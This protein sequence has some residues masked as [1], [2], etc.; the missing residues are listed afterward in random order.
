MLDGSF[1][2]SEALAKGLVTRHQLYGPRFRRVLPDV[3]VPAGLK[4]DLPARSQAAY[5]LVRNRGGVLAGYSAAA[6][7]GAD[8]APRRAPAEVLV[9]TR[10]R[11]QPGLRVHR[12]RVEPGE[13]V[14]AG[15]CRMTGALRTAWDLARWR[16]LVDGVVA[17]D[18]L[19][20]TGGFSPAALL[21]P[22][23]GYPAARGCRRLPAVVE[24]ADPRAESPMETRVRVRLILAGLP[25]PEVQFRVV[26]EYG[27]VLARVDL[28]Y[29]E[30]KLA[31][32]Y[33]G[34][35][36]FTPAQARRDRQRDAELA[37]LGWLTLRLGPDDLLAMPQTVLRI[38][39]LLAQR[40]P[41]YAPNGT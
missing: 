13:L 11:P 39:T 27:F 35:V 26:D 9:P 5:L 19:A 14:W 12:D 38:R 22:R 23:T 3:Y 6:L 31:I 7:L 10:Q 29:P 15:G 28:A 41:K 16:S 33:D 2:G 30:A 25:A 32:E 8:C 34:A 21:D 1:R 40:T 24:L 4:L 17:V 18:A 36:H 37:S 20:R